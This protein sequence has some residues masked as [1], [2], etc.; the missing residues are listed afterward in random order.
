MN[1]LSTRSIIPWCV[2]MNLFFWCLI[3]LFDICVGENFNDLTKAILCLIFFILNF[4]YFLYIISLYMAIVYKSVISIF[5]YLTV[6]KEWTHKK[7]LSIWSLL[8]IMI[9]NTLTWAWLFTSLYYFNENFYIGNLVNE[10]GQFFINTIRFWFFTT[11]VSNSFSFGLIMPSGVVVE[12]F[13]A[14]L[15]NQTQFIYLVLYG[16]VISTIISSL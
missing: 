4:S 8:N 15:I 2:V 3:W 1:P 6:G 10:P 16:G 14:I 9:G 12:F 5:K 7:G 13:C 11:G